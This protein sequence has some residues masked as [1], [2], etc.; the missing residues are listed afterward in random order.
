MPVHNGAGTPAMSAQTC[1]W[2]GEQ[3]G[4]TCSSLSDEA[5]LRH[6]FSATNHT[7]NQETWKHRRELFEKERELA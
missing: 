7:C 1:K 5:L 2:C 4:N 3:G 6:Y